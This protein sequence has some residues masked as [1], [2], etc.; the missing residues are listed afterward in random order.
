MYHDASGSAEL[1]VFFGELPITRKE[2]NA[3]S[4]KTAVMNEKG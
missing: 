4:F 3:S 2:T 1:L